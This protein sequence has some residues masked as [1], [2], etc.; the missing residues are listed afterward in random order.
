[1]LRSLLLAASAVLAGV[2]V[3]EAQ[4]Y[5]THG[6]QGPSNSPYFETCTG[7]SNC[8]VCTTSA[9]TPSGTWESVIEGA[10]AG[11]TVLLRNGT[12][13]PSD[14]ALDI[15][16]GS[17]HAN[18]VLIANFEDELPLI[19][20]A[21]NPLGSYV[22]LQGLTIET[23]ENT[24]ALHIEENSNTPITGVSME[25]LEV[26]GGTLE[27]VRIRANVQ[28]SILQHSIIDGGEEAH[29]I[30]V[31]C[32]SETHE[33]CE[34]TPENIQI[35]NNQV[36][37]TFFDVATEDLLQLEGVGEVTV[38]NNDFNTNPD[39]EEC[40]DVKSFGRANGWIY[41]GFNE[42]RANCG[43]LQII[44]PA[45]PGEIVVEGNH[46]SGDGGSLVRN[47]AN[48]NLYNNFVE[49]HEITLAGSPTDSIVAFNTFAGG[50]LTFGDSAGAPSND[51]AITDN[52]FDGTAFQG[53][54]GSWTVETNV[55]F[56]TS[57]GTLGSCTGCINQDP[58]LSGYE[59]P[60]NSPAVDA[61][62]DF[63][64]AIDIEDT[65]RPEG[66]DDDIGAFEVVQ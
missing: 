14:T 46:F 51:V 31:L 10:T 47:A 66:N 48:V 64:V 18:R 36:R 16:G 8:F 27:A 56:Q 12:F 21:V 63:H 39:G 45:T 62:G 38:T 28:D 29:A 3:A 61:S 20:G 19:T 11:R 58:L 65:S 42:I 35:H 60:G 34:W 40:V 41:I 50:A 15:P 4:V 13:D 23:D 54:S 59:I 43:G 9:C 55:L 37:K 24:W 25:Y 52:I 33:N 26:R 53:T 49:D 32:D 1:M 7:L 22:H 2:G 57:G 17:S 6:G 5:G 30:K 44:Q